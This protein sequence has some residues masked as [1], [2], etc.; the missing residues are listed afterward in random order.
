MTRATFRIFIR[1]L[2]LGDHTFGRL[3][4]RIY[5][6]LALLGFSNSATYWEKR[7]QRGGSSGAGSYDRLARFKAEYLN[8]FVAENAVSSVVEFGCGDGAQLG[9]AQYPKYL[10][11]DVSPTAIQ[12]CKRRFSGDPTKS[13]AISGQDVGQHDL[14]LSL[15]VIYHLVEDSAYDDYMHS[16]FSSARNFVIIYSSNKIEDSFSPH[17]R[18]RLFTEWIKANCADWRMT[19]HVA[20]PYRYDPRDPYATSFADFYVFAR[21]TSPAA[22]GPPV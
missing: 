6:S 12:M 5:A 18:H 8:R 15:D 14:A 9:L 22:C 2:V 16:L 11:L 4:R 17:V 20:N 7:Y 21:A 3:G 13:F 10:G 1:R 19:Q